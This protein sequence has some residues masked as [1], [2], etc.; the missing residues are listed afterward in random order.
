MKISSYYVNLFFSMVGVI[1]IGMVA[2]F[3]EYPKEIAAVFMIQTYTF[4][5]LLLEIGNLKSN[6][7][8]RKKK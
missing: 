8:K 3:L 1:L 7:I 4:L 5:F 6:S 2:L